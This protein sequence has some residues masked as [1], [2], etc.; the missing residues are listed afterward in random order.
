MTQQEAFNIMVQHLRTQGSPSYYSATN[1]FGTGNRCY[2]RHPDG[3]KRCAVGVLIS[4]KDYA[5]AL[6]YLSAARLVER[7]LASLKGL[8]SEFLCTMQDSHDSVAALARGNDEAWRRLME[9]EY[10]HIAKDYR[11]TVPQHPCQEVEHHD[12]PEELHQPCTSIEA[13]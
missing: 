7:Q 11:L 2:Y 10:I 3:I 6:E 13:V 1:N 5:P 8:T 9:D 12:E 4:D